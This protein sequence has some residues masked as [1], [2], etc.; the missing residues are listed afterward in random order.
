YSHRIL[1]RRTSDKRSLLAPVLFGTWLGV[2]AGRDPR[3]AAAPERGNLGPL[4]RLSRG[5]PH[6]RPGPGQ[7]RK[8]VST[9]LD[10]HLT[11]S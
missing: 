6:R 11:V 4:G 9:A 2:G 1:L 10:G 7:A 8:S 3:P 5:A